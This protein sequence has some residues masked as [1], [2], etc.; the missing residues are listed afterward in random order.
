MNK[1]FMKPDFVLNADRLEKREINLVVDSIFRR[2][3]LKTP[4]KIKKG[5]LWI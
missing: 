2:V 3:L 5:V 4:L 1:Y